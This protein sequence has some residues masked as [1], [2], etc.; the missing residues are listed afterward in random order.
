MVRPRNDLYCDSSLAQFYD[1]D[2]GWAADL[3]YCLALAR[4]AHSVL[5]LGCGTGLLASR[6][7]D[8][9]Q[10]VG[11]DAASAML[12][13]ARR[14]PGGDRV[15]WVEEDAR[16]L[17]LNRVFDLV[18]MTGHAFQVFLT[19]EDQRSAVGA[20]ARH[21][22]PGGC[23]IFDTRNPA[24]RAW[25]NWTP[26]VSV[27]VLRHPG[28]GEVKAWNDASYD[29]STCVV[30]YQTYYRVIA[31]GEIFSADSKIKFTPKDRIAPLLEAAGLTVDAWL[32]DWL[33]N[34]YSDSAPDI[35]PR[36]RLAGAKR[37]D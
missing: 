21:L 14:R 3:E 13:I 10:V 29:A 20:V 31:T 28:F 1:L 23:F 18:L 2:N 7:A 9:R 27:R 15:E 4:H 19:A 34:E 17:R 5:D 22:A 33:G 25:R 16:A 11:V 24:A 26:G 32:G 36:G 8:E 35:I 30:T 6:L 37:V 12:D